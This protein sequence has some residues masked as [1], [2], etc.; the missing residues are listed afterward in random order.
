MVHSI[1]QPLDDSM[2]QHTVLDH[3][4]DTTID[5]LFNLGV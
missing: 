4:E 2:N 3:V 5:T 1:F